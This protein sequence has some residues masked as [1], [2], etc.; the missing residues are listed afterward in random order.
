M[1]DPKRGIEV[2]PPERAVPVFPAEFQ[3]WDPALGRGYRI[4]NANAVPSGAGILNSGIEP[5][6]LVNHGEVNR[7]GRWK[8]TLMVKDPAGNDVTRDG[9]GLRFVVTARM[10]ND[11]IPRTCFVTLGD[12]QV[13][14]APGR[15]M[16]VIAINPSAIDL[17][18]HWNID[19]VTAGLSRWEDVQVFDA[20]GGETDLELPPFCGSFEVFGVMGQAAPM[21]RGYGPGGTLLY[22]EIIGSPRSG[23][24]PRI[25]SIDFTLQ[26][27]APPT[28]HTVLFVCDG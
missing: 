16:E 18:A 2:R 5:V 9:V 11:I 17:E 12:A 15:A 10:E 27:G 14:Y 20:L 4:G 22:S 26:S 7:I 24:I 19:E 3:R 23:P 25:P 1:R 13:I 28:Q 6:T 8:V 21:L